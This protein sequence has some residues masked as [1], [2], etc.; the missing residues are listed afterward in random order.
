MKLIGRWLVTT[1]LACGLLLLLG[2]WR[3]PLLWIYAALFSAV[4]LYA[5]TQ[6]GEDLARERFTPPS[7]GADRL[8]LR[9]VRLVAL[10]HVVAGALDSRY[11]WTHIPDAL[12]IV[13]LAGFGASFLLIVHAMKA[14]RF[15]SSVVRIQSERGHHVVES[16]P[17]RIVRHPGYAAMIPLV[18]FSGLALGSWIAFALAFAYS[19]LILRR[20][21]FEDGFLHANLAGYAQYAARV[22]YRLVP[23]VW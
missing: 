15:F 9:T 7:S 2:D 13:G 18:P 22:R 20:V 21:R 5:M 19:W 10:A 3:D 14:N 16:G 6:M 11:G 1:T 17:Y 12:R 4:G 8:S 23:G